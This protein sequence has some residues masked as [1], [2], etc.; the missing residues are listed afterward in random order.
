MIC[1]KIMFYCFVEQKQGL[2]QIYGLTVEIIRQQH[3]LFTFFCILSE[4]GSPA[5][6]Y[7]LGL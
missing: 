6:A 3:G 4:C 5:L 2:Y 7:G 1:Y